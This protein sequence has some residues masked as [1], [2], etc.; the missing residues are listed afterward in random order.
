MDLVCFWQMGSSEVTWTLWL[1]N[2]YISGITANSNKTSGCKEAQSIVFIFWYEFKWMLWN[3]QLWKC[4]QSGRTL[5]QN[6]T[7]N[8]LH[9][10]R[11]SL[12]GSGG[13]IKSEHLPTWRPLVASLVAK[14]DKSKSAC[15]SEYRCD[16]NSSR[17][18]D[19]GQGWSCGH[20]AAVWT[21]VG[22]GARRWLSEG[23][24]GQRKGRGPCLETAWGLPSE[25]TAVGATVGQ[26]ELH[27]PHAKIISPASR[28]IVHIVCEADTRL[29]CI[30]W[31]L[32]V[33]ARVRAFATR[34]I[35]QPEGIVSRSERIV[36]WWERFHKRDET[37]ERI[38]VEANPS[39]TWLWLTYKPQ[40][41][42]LCVKHTLPVVTRCC[43]TQGWTGCKGNG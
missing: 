38:N 18:W 16:G 29:P 36:A 9:S 23:P 1:Q 24:A 15:P 8:V 37:H 12:Y 25:G 39:T 10:R 19:E 28:N 27:K 35:P 5:K 4:I 22:E 13:I 3:I 17:V 31:N 21:S 14:V 20:A 40:T 43:T 30:C 32:F 7:F 33:S 11:L 6:K 42:I 26:T 2:L 34:V 41:G